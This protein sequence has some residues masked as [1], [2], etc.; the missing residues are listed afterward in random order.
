[1]SGTSRAKWYWLLVLVVILQVLIWGLYS[2]Y[3]TRRLGSDASYKPTLALRRRGTGF[4]NHSVHVLMQKSPR[5]SRGEVIRIHRPFILREKGEMLSNHTLRQSLRCT[6]FAKSFTVD[7]GTCLNLLI[8]IKG[9]HNGSSYPAIAARAVGL[10]NRSGKCN[11]GSVIVFSMHSRDRNVCHV[12]MKILLGFTVYK[13][14]LHSPGWLNIPPVQTV[15]LLVSKR[16]SALYSAPKGNFRSFHAGLL[17]SIF[18]RHGVTVVVRQTLDQLSVSHGCYAA[19]VFV[20]SHANRFAFPD[21]TLGKNASYY[22]SLPLAFP[23]G[24][25]ALALRGHI[26]KGE[27]LPQMRF[28]VLYVARKSGR[29]TW[30]KKSEIK[31]RSMLRRVSKRKGAQLVIFEGKSSLGFAKQVNFFADASVIIGFHGAGLALAAFAPR[32]ATLIEIE[33]DYHSLGLFGNLQSSGLSYK[34]LHLRK[35]TMRR[36]RFTS[37]LIPEDEKIIAS[38]LE[39]CLDKV[40]AYLKTRLTNRVSRKAKAIATYCIRQL[41]AQF[42]VPIAPFVSGSGKV[43]QMGNPRRPAGVRRRY[44]PAGHD[45]RNRNR[46]AGPVQQRCIPR[47]MNEDCRAQSFAQHIRPK[48]KVP[49]T[50]KDDIDMMAF[51]FKCHAC[52][53][54][55]PFETSLAMHF[56]PAKMRPVM[57]EHGCPTVGSSIQLL[58]HSPNG[59]ENWARP[60]ALPVARQSTFSITVPDGRPCGFRFVCARSQFL[61][62]CVFPGR[63]GLTAPLIRVPRRKSTCPIPEKCTQVA[64]LGASCSNAHSVWKISATRCS[65][66]VPVA[67]SP[68]LARASRRAAGCVLRKVRHARRWGPRAGMVCT[69]LRRARWH[70]KCKKPMGLDESYKDRLRAYEPG[71]GIREVA[72]FT[73]GQRQ[74]TGHAVLPYSL[75][76]LGFD[77]WG[78]VSKEVQEAG[79]PWES[80]KDRFWACVPDLECKDTRQRY[81]H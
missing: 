13:R 80:C 18:T 9:E 47:S 40:P 8:P 73:Q 35:G 3:S 74:Y 39:L 6:D 64:L 76:S 44:V 1:M 11:K 70:S 67:R 72:L 12:L 55:F 52:M 21:A 22:G 54:F 38:V 48:I 53:R 10:S 49:K 61:K 59:F 4:G 29:R 33:P 25:D 42:Y 46:A 66:A 68:A 28:K 15:V 16:A 26:F 37:E 36:I 31:M 79:G 57:D 56:R 81:M 17:R 45:T 43:A 34:R 75:T 50:T 58:A 7:S 2:A 77:V 69:V 14:A 32:G 62:V 60:A 63:L 19:G 27:P 51:K 71:A 24:S 30:T 5:R 78:R 20:G 23:L 41:V 65:V